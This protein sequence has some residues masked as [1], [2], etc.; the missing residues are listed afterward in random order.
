MPVPCLPLISVLIPVYN[1]ERYVGICLESVVKQK[2][3]QLEIIVVDD[4]STDRSGEICD[5]YAQK[6]GRIKVIHKANGGLVS[7]RK[8]AMQVAKGAY[9]GY[10]DGDDWIS[11]DYYSDLFLKIEGN[12]CDA[13]VAGFSR[14]L[15]DTSTPMSNVVPAGCYEGEKLENLFS[16]MIST[17]AFFRHG[18]TTYLWNKLFKREIV[19][20]IQ[21]GIDDRISIGEDGAVVYPA[22][23]KCKRVFVT[24]NFSYHYRQREDSML[25]KSRPFE[26]EISQLQ[27]L[28]NQIDN[29]IERYP[30]SLNLRLQLQKYV[31]STCIIRSGGIVDSAGGTKYLPFEKD[32]KGKRVVICGAGTFGQQL[33]KRLRER[34]HCDITAWVDYDYW[35][36]RRCCLNVDPLEKLIE[37]EFDFIVLGTV[38]SQATQ[39]MRERLVSM[40]IES[41]KILSI[42]TEDDKVVNALSHYLNLDR[43]EN[44]NKQ[45]AGHL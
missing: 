10:V 23:L 40:G 37:T 24:N 5:L 15:F 44:L 34:N 42:R 26:Q 31:L 2:Y 8:A 25:K 32:L 14:D 21:L 27:V 4:G 20:G 11:P 1:I 29:A 38:D 16:N 45:T 36:Y 43:Q 12:N 19:E 13:V 30:A 3:R 41:E 6:D 33:E 35:E 22:L 9:I 7:A 18:I 39:S 17:G 28:Y